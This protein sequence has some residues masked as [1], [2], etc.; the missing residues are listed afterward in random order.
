MPDLERLLNDELDRTGGV[1]RLKP[2]FVARTFYPGLGRLGVKKYYVGKR[3]W[4][5]ER[6]IASSVLADNPIPVANEGLSFIAFSK[7]G[8][9]LSLKEA[10]ELKPARMV[11]KNYAR[12]HGDRFGVLTKVLDI[13]SPIPWHIHA[14]EEDAKKYWG[15]TSKEEAYYFLDALERGPLL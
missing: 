6:W 15:M 14:R 11:G 7:G 4:L 8:A 5:C 2:A 3:G 1:L 12:E 9:E 10:L 13:G